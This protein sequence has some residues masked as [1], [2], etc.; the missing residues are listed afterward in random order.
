LIIV[1][2]LEGITSYSGIVNGYIPNYKINIYLH[3]IIF[4]G[5]I[6]F[7]FTLIYTNF[8][9][10][11]ATYGILLVTMSIIFGIECLISLFIFALIVISNYYKLLSLFFYIF[12]A[13]PILILLNDE[14]LKDFTF[15]TNT[16][17]SFFLTLIFA[18]FYIP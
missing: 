14:G 16:Y 7:G 8:L 11:V 10:L 15:L 3:I 12:F 9:I 6:F 1:F 18:L 4:S 2:A 13:I 5:I 17:F